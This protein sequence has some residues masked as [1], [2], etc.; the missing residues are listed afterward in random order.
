M[1]ISRR[2]WLRRSRRMVVTSR[3]L[4]T[5]KSWLH[6]LTGSANIRLAARVDGRITDLMEF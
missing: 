3:R 6:S 1:P 5:R 4:S 2:V